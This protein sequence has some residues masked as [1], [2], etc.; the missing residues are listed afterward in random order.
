[1]G[2][3]FS[4]GPAVVLDDS[5]VLEVDFDVEFADAPFELELW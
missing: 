5:F 1:M 4:E 2:G 3:F